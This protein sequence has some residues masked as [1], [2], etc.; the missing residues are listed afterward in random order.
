MA[1]GRERRVFDDSFKAAA[2]ARKVAGEP[3]STIAKDLGIHVNLVRRWVD[4]SG[5][6]G[7][8]V[9]SERPPGGPGKPVQAPRRPQATMVARGACEATLRARN[10]Y[11][12]KVL[13][14]HGIQY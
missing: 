7:T 8:S 1:N 5:S 2:V 10:E 6:G 9:V 12:E 13:K 4:L 14:I 3:F 11:L